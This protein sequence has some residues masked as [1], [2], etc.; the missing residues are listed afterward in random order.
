VVN[1]RGKIRVPPA[2]DKIDVSAAAGRTAQPPPIDHDNL[3]ATARDLIGDVGLGPMLAAFAPHDQPHLGGD[4]M[5]QRHRRRLALASIAPHN[6][7]IPPD[8]TEDDKAALVDLLRDTIAV[9]RF[10]LSP[11]VMCFSPKSGGGLPSASIFLLI[12]AARRPQGSEEKGR[13]CD[14][15]R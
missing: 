3:G 11:V 13:S 12:A 7:T 6:P 4:R 10:P 9:D 8:L 14:R 5:A 15:P 2:D 1:T